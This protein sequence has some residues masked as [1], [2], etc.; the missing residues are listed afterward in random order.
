MQATVDRMAEDERTL[1]LG[2]AFALAGQK[3]G[4]ITWVVDQFEEVFTLCTSEI[5]RTQFFANLLYASS[6][7]DGCCT[8]LLTMRAD[9]LPK[10]A[11]YPD[12]AAR[13]AAQQFLVS[14]MDVEMLRQVINEP[15]RRVGLT[16]KPGL[17]DTILSD[18]ASEPGAL[19]LLEHALLELWKRRNDQT[20]TLES[21]RESGGVKGAIAK[22]AEETFKGLSADEQPIIRRIMLRLTQLGEGTEDT[23]RRA[24][25][26]ELVTKPEEADAV[27][28]ITR[29]MTDARLL[30]TGR[31]TERYVDVAHEALIRGWP[32]LRQWLDEDRAGLRLHHRISEGA[33]EW[34]R[35]NRDD[36]LLYRGTRLAQAQEW[37]ER[38]EPELNPLERKFLDASAALKQRLE[39]QERERQQRELDSFRRLAEEQ[40]RRAELSEQREKEQKQAARKLQRRA[41]IAIGLGAIAL[42]LGVRSES[43]R[44]LAEQRAQSAEARARIAETLLKSVER[45]W[46]AALAEADKAKS[47]EERERLLQAAEKAFTGSITRINEL[48]ASF[49][50]IEGTERSTPLLD[51][52]IRILKEQG[53]DEALAYVATQRP[54]ILEKVKARAAAAHEKNRAELL[55]LLKSAHQQADRNQPEEAERLYTEILDLEPAWPEA[56]NALAV[57]LVQ[58]GEV[59]EPAQGNAKLREAVQICQGTLAFNQREKSPQDWAATQNNLGNA[60]SELGTRSG[61]EEARKLLEDGVAAFRSA[62]DVRTRKQLPQEWAM[63]QNNLGIALKEQAIRTGGARGTELLAQAV[64]AY[65]NA[66]EIYTRR[67]RPQEWAMTQDNLGAALQKQ[68]IRGEGAQSAEL[69][70][71][72]VAAF[73]CALEV[74]TRE[75]LPQDWATTQNNLGL[76]LQEQGTRTAGDQGTEL[77]AQAVA[78]FRSALEVRTREQLPQDWATTQNNLG[79]ALAEQSSRA[80]GAQGTELLTQAVAALRSALEVRT[81]EQLPQQWATTQNNLG[82]ALADQSTRAEGA[83]STELLTQAMTAFRNALEVYT[84]EV[85]PAYH[86]MVQANLAKTEEQLKGTKAPH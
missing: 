22:T 53:V 57:F 38:N 74:R 49:A 62:L 50:E 23:R 44:L 31:D 12:L 2:V 43:Y 17:V 61:G 52:M 11:S 46:Q 78:A 3:A 24:L 48:A 72:A 47:W 85:F 39:Q 6:I 5:E 21:Y 81:R 67:E 54:A 28:R 26:T 10:C 42:M 73:R 4:H 66:L 59:I 71:Q 35:A 20:L 32:R 1:H 37:R 41:W 79:L 68:A 64:A 86:E 27:D 76:A 69:L 19:P 80:E 29:L 84:P 36:E 33:Q 15:A 77:L 7:P 25:L 8:V 13:M 70:A 14:P 82:L 83:Q 40:E 51:E 9:F 45:N 34:Q 16:F 55:P 65:R 75:Q 30:I 63:T 18:V 56:R 60:L 58:R